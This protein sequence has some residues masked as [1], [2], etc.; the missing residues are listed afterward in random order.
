V[1]GDPMNRLVV[2]P[3]LCACH[4]PCAELLPEAV[5]LDEWGFPLLAAGPVPEELLRRARQTAATCPTRALRLA[6]SPA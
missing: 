6:P 2:D 4:G 5:T 1:P 3:I